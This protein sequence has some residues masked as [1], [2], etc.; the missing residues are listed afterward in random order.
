MLA[1]M[2]NPF[3]K[4]LAQLVEHKTL[5]HA[6]GFLP[7]LG[8]ILTLNFVKFVNFHDYNKI[9]KNSKIYLSSSFRGLTSV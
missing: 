4:Q 7:T 6:Y 1:R 9:P 2:P 3:C 5:H 8:A